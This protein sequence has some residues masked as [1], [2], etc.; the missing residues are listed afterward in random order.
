MKKVCFIISFLLLHIYICKAQEQHD[1]NPGKVEDV[2]MEYMSRE[3]NLTPEEAQKFWPLYNNYFNEVKNARKKYGNDEVAMDEKM[4][5]IRKKYKN[6]FRSVLNSDNRVNRVFVSE[7]SFRDMVK[8]ESFDRQRRKKY[9]AIR[10][11][12]QFKPKN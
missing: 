6:N 11:P 4:V 5:E 7:K 3:L 10:Q 9:P 2:K 1:K 12:K 8:K